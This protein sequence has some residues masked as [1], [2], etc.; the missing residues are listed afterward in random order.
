M[1]ARQNCSRRFPGSATWSWPVAGRDR[2]GPARVLRD[3]AAAGVLGDSL[4]GQLHERQEEQGRPDRRRRCLHQAAA[5]AGRLG[6]GPSA[7]TAPGQV[8]PA[9]PPVRRD[10]EQGR[11]QR[12]II[13]IAH[14][15]LKI[16]YQVLK[17]GPPTPTSASAS[18]TAASP[19]RP[20]RTTWSAS[21]K[22]ST[23]AA[24][25]PSP[26]RRPPDSPGLTTAPRAD[27]LATRPPTLKPTAQTAAGYCRAPGTHPI[28]C[29]FICSTVAA[30]VARSWAGSLCRFR[31]ILFRRV[32]GRTWA[33]LSGV[34]QLLSQGTLGDGA[35]P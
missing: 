11:G 1:P 16:A 8:Q 23:P 26:R 19:P 14:T 5:G 2:T 20:S 24:S 13:A 33:L 30:V 12:A 31:L 29:Q 4:P 28:S 21:C 15:L 35:F 10:Q 32:T 7:R 34:A 9:G 17:A 22:S 3:R 18:T 25:S 6:R 27:R